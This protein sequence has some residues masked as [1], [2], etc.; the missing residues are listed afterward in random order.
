MSRV[1][2]RIGALLVTLGIGCADASGFRA[3]LLPVDVRSD[4]PTARERLAACE[5]DPRVRSGLLA[6]EVC[7]DAVVF[8]SEAL[9][10][11]AADHAERHESRDT[12]DRSETTRGRRLL[13]ATYQPTG[14]D[15]WFVVGPSS[16]PGRPRA[17]SGT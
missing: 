9:D 17:T 11:A 16:R 13:P 2:P 14:V 1:R 5:Q 8:S 4:E 7:A 12:L 3:E 10:G 15:F 6:R